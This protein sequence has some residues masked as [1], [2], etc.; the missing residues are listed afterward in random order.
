MKSAAAEDER[1]PQQ[2]MNKK[3]YLCSRCRRSAAAVK[4]KE[5][6]RRQRS[7]SEDLREVNKLQMNEMGCE[8]VATVDSEAE[9]ACKIS[10]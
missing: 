4:T 10:T 5:P 3:N 1:L 9:L 7:S 6:Q 2:P 8:K